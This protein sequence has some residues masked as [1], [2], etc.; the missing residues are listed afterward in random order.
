MRVV[1]PKCLLENS[2]DPDRVA[3]GEEKP[4]CRNCGHA[5]PVS[6]KTENFAPGAEENRKTRARTTPARAPSAFEAVEAKTAK[7][8]SFKRPG[9]G[10]ETRGVGAK[11]ASAESKGREGALQGAVLPLKSPSGTAADTHR[12]SFH[13]N[14]STLL[15]MLIVNN[16]LSVLTLGVYHFWGKTK[17]RKYLYGSTEFMGDRFAYTGTGKEL[18]LGWM[19][20]AGVMAIVFGAPEALSRFAH[21][22]L[23]LL[24]IPAMLFLVPFA[25]ASS[26]RFRMSRTAWRG[27]R[28][29]FNGSPLEFVKLYVSGAMLNFLTFGLYSPYFHARKEGFLRSHTSFGTG[30]FTYTGSGRDLKKDFLLALPLTIATSGLY[31]FWYKA[32]VTRYDWEHTGFNNCLRF[33]SNVT[34]KDLLFFNLANFALLALSFGF[35]QPWVAA[36]GLQFT[37]GHLTVTGKVDFS[38]LGQTGKAA[39]ATGE[40]LADAFDIDVAM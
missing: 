8:V 17:I 25:V 19:K 39:E 31:W 22:A 37:A 29:S 14:A 27:V 28:F 34:G 20:A 18:F 5:L 21:P 2:V 12:P 13:G 24:T 16:L 10:E 9:P 3:L 32:R 40:G 15:K 38:T 36:R 26:R 35:A 11:E 23:K 4:E 7:V 30:A 6:T 1:C 33:T